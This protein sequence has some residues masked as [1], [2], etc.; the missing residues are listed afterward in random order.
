MQENK[1]SLTTCKVCGKEISVLSKECPG[2]GHQFYVTIFGMFFFAAFYLI[3]MQQIHPW[4]WPL[5]IC[6]LLYL[7][8]MVLSIITGITYRVSSKPGVSEKC[9]LINYILIGIAIVF[10]HIVY[11]F[12]YKY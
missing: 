8:S 12:L 10:Q 6:H 1:G 7:V 3:E 9:R 4:H 11:A 5:K 2:C